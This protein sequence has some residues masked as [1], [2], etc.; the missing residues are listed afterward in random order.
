MIIAREAR[1]KC[2]ICCIQS[3]ENLVI[4]SMTCKC[5]LDRIWSKLDYLCHA[6]IYYIIKK[7]GGLKPPQAVYTLNRC[8]V[9]FVYHFIT[10]LGIVTAIL[11]LLKITYAECIIVTIVKFNDIFNLVIARVDNKGEYRTHYMACAGCFWKVTHEEFKYW[12]ERSIQIANS[13]CGLERLQRDSDW[14][15]WQIEI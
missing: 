4:C 10:I 9:G 13:G 3:L 11:I 12:P 6:H 14:K 8:H 2:L 1:E 7:W 15:H 5:I